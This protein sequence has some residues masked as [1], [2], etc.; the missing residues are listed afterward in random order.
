MLTLVCEILRAR[1]YLLCYKC[2][3]GFYNDIWDT[4]G[5]LRAEFKI[6]LIFAHCCILQLSV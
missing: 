1:I 2:A 6:C 4:I 3:G 5:T